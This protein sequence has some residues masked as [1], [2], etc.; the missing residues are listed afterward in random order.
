MLAQLNQYIQL[1]MDFTKANPVI[2]GLVSLW[3]LG[4]LTFLLKNVPSKV[5]R[6]IKRQCT[7]T[8]TMNNTEVGTNQDVFNNFIT[9][10]NNS[11]WS[12]WSRS[13]SVDGKPSSWTRDGYDPGGVTVGIGEGSHFFMKGWRPFWVYRRKV[14]GSQGTRNIFFEISITMLGRKRDLLKELYDEFNPPVISTNLSVM[15]HMSDKGWVRLT[16]TQKRSLSSVITA[17][18]VKEDIVAKIKWWKANRQWYLDRG[19]PHKLVFVLEGP[20][21]TGKTSLI[22]GVA[23]EFEMNLCLFTLPGQNQ[24][25]LQSAFS[26]IPDNSLVV[27]EDFDSCRALK[28]RK[29]VEDVRDAAAV[30]EKAEVEK[31]PDGPRLIIDELLTLSDILNAFDG[32]VSLDNSVFFLTTN[33]LSDIDPAFLRPGR[34][35]YQ[36]HVGTLSH[37]DICDYV[38]MMFPQTVIP[39]GIRFASL[40]GCRVQE[41]YFEHR[42]DVAGFIDALP[43][44][45]ECITPTVA[46]EIDR[47]LK[48]ELH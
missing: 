45:V 46:H 6:F 36:I 30:N 22:K 24:K 43:K 11:K 25:S 37:T 7:T 41:I 39:E 29:N 28:K 20:P 2:A 12:R 19:L 3:G 13:M 17:N 33:D 35:D 27:L 8:L 5:G 48:G 40:V 34:V 31:K 21:G 14:E 32:V 42:D 44:E 38:R 9:W 4:V 16:Q 1:F 23:S 10:L 15:V 47:I 18:G 26:S